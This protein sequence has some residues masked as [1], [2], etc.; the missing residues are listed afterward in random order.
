MNASTSLPRVLIFRQKLL[1]YSETF[2]LSQ[3]QGLRRFQPYFIGLKRIPGLTPPNDTSCTLAGRGLKADAAS[4]LF[5]LTHFAPRFIS[6]LRS[7]NPVLIHAHFEDGGVFALPIAKALGIPLITTFHGYDATMADEVCRPNR[8]VRNL[9]KLGRERLKQQGSL[10]IAVSD[11]IRSKV[12]AKGYDE[13]RVVKHHIGVD[14]KTFDA[15]DMERQPTILFV[16]RLVEK[17]GCHY[18]LEAMAKVAS[19]RSDAQLLIIGDGPQRATL[20]KYAADTRLANVR[21]VGAQTSAVI[22]DEMARAMILAA[23]SITAQS[24]DS[25]GLPIVVCEAQAMGL[26][27]VASDHAGIP[28]IVKHGR[29]GFL[30]PERDVNQL[31]DRIIELLSNPSTWKSFSKAARTN[32]VERFDLNRQCEQ[33]DQIYSNTVEEHSKCKL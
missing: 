23:P 25:E 11:F 1:N 16:G 5:K 7:L 27:V 30:F 3:A 22:R 21:F 8:I 15:P 24:G 14:T 19:V 31:A 6:K 4:A 26:P 28:E 18:L 17:K 20:E 9:Y 29:T 13:S 2:V 10:S 33:L 12:I 32:V